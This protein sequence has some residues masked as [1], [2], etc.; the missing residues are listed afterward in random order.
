MS[1]ALEAVTVIDTEAYIS[2]KHIRS[3]GGKLCL[4]KLIKI[5][6]HGMTLLAK[7]GFHP[8]SYPF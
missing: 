6:T 7:G 3:S 8:G 4:I 5:S 1:V 2:G